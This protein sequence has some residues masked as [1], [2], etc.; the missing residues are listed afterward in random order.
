MSA[1]CETGAIFGGGDKRQQQAMREFGKD[2]GMAFQLIDDTLDYTGEAEELGKPVGN[3][4]QAGKA[5]LP[6][7]HAMQHCT[8]SQRAELRRIFAGDEIGTQEF[9]RVKELVTRTGGIE[10]TRNLAADHIR[11][12]REALEFFPDHPAKEILR[13][14]ADFVVCRRV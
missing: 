1:A 2:L 6:L 5:T 4:I 10:F 12:A 7:I 13:D 9:L 14:M 8:D 11:N 3:D